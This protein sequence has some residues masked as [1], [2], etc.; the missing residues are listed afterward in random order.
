MSEEDR[1]NVD[2]AKS[3]RIIGPFVASSY[4]ESQVVKSIIEESPVV[5]Y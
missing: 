3:A 5:K 1:S 4:G 2:D